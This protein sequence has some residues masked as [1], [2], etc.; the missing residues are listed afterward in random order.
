L[1]ILWAIIPM[2]F[3]PIGP[4]FKNF[5]PSNAYPSKSLDGTCPSQVG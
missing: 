5:I 1:W 4:I 3:Y 2:I